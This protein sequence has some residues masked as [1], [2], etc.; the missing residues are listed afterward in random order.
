[1]YVNHV[2]SILQT[3]TKEKF[4]EKYLELSNFW[5]K[6]FKGYFD[7]HLK[8]D[9]ITYAS[10]WVL[11]SHN[12]FDPYSGITNNMAESLNH[13]IKRIQAWKEM[14]ADVIALSFYKF[15]NYYLQ[16]ILRGFCGLGKFKLK[17]E[18]HRLKKHSKDQGFPV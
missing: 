17:D 13:A 12:L 9:L 11:S 5:A 8:K 18:F 7:D 3:E 4:E 14:K 6:D 1:M 10:R 2:E 16:E 15:Q